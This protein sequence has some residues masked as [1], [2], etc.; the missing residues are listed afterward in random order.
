MSR[1]QIYDWELEWINE[2][3]NEWKPTLSN[4]ELIYRRLL[5]LR[6]YHEHKDVVRTVFIFAHNTNK[7]IT[8]DFVRKTI[9]NFRNRNNLDDF[10]TTA[11]AWPQPPDEA[12]A[13]NATS[14]TGLILAILYWVF[15]KISE[16]HGND[17]VVIL[18][19]RVAPL[20]KHVLVKLLVVA[21]SF[22]GLV[23]ASSA[24]QSALLGKNITDI[25][26]ACTAE[27]EPT[28]S[29]MIVSD[30]TST[31]T[32][33]ATPTHTHTPSSTPPVTATYTALPPPA[34][35]TPTLNP[36]TAPATSSSTHILSAT[37]RPTIDICAS[38]RTENGC[39]V[40]VVLSG[41]VL[42]DGS[43]GEISLPQNAIVRLESLNLDTMLYEATYCDPERGSV[44]GSLLLDP[45]DSAVPLS[46]ANCPP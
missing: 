3:I 20:L 30:E 34:T 29:V 40:Q 21:L 11:K 26:C 15:E 46:D 33:G 38:F 19:N 32:P 2:Q 24:A 1:I 18:E 39:Y 17:L 23:D 36:S 44:S 35:D 14:L 4:S 27:E 6:L 8:D 37:P 12:R 41:L 43:P 31:P 42:R 5:T 7:T 16:E 22:F 13:N 28:E 9:F 10:K 45:I 25:V